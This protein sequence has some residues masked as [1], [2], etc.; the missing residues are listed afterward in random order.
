MNKT[1]LVVEYL[2][3]TEVSF[4]NIE[5]GEVFMEI[6]AGLDL[7]G[8]EGGHLKLVVPRSLFY[9]WWE[10]ALVREG[11][12]QIKAA[13]VEWLVGALQSGDDNGRE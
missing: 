12:K 11:V 2:Q 7:P 13:F 3:V 6:V 10:K 8:T 5:S 1:K 9:Q 4:V